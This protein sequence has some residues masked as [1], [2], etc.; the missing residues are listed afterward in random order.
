M[1]IKVRQD[2]AKTGIFVSCD[3]IISKGYMDIEVFS[4]PRADS[5]P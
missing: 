2:F 4:R 3:I 1:E 5:L